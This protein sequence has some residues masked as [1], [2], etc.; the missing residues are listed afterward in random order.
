MVKSR[1]TRERSNLPAVNTRV[2]VLRFCLRLADWA[3]ALRSF[4]GDLNVSLRQANGVI[5]EAAA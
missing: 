2:P 5:H 3:V 4:S 1:L